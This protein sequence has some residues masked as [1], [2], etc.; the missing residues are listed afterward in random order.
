MYFECTPYKTAIFTGKRLNEI[1]FRALE[2]LGTVD[3][4]LSNNRVFLLSKSQKEKLSIAI[5]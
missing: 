2:E 3:V 5:F 1:D 4:D